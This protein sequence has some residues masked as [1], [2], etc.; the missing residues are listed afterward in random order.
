MRIN[1]IIVE[2]EPLAGKLL[3]EYVQQ[4][5]FL[6]LLALCKDALSAMKVLKEEKVELMFLDINLPKLRGLDLLKALKNP[7]AVILTTAYH[8]YALESYDYGVIDYLLKP[9]EFS[10]F[11]VAINK[12]V[13]SAPEPSP[14][15][16]TIA[17][18]SNAYLFFNVN[19]KKARVALDEV[20]YIESIKENVKIVTLHKTIVTKYNISQLELDLP[21]AD[22][23]RIH[24]SF[25]VAKNKVD[26]FDANDV[27][28]RGKEIP[29][30]RS[31]KELVFKDLG[32]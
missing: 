9:I 18:N 20:L 4:V 16:T 1:C 6:H 22:F 13:P 30:G 19:K 23:L 10:R 15:V 28:I 8:E 26:F 17:A 14:T 12:V 11:L 24:R 27:E 32:A 21:Q 5:P 31:Y 3:E 2:D 7:P 25:I 29:I